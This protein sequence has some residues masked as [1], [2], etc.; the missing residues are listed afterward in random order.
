MYSLLIESNK[1]FPFGVFTAQKPTLVSEVGPHVKDSNQLLCQ[2][3][4]LYPHNDTAKIMTYLFFLKTL[5]TT[6]KTIVIQANTVVGKLIN[7]SSQSIIL[8]GI[9]NMTLPS[10]IVPPIKNMSVVV[11]AF[12]ENKYVMIA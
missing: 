2:N 4:T 8:T 12:F 3:K 1:T 9:S 10:I 6:V 11:F 7:V 5:I